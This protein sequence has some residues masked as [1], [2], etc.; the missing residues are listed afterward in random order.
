MPLNYLKNSNWEPFAKKRIQEIIHYYGNT[1]SV[2]LHDQPYAVFDFD[3]TSCFFDIE[4][5]LMLYMIE[6][7]AFR[8]NAETFYHILSCD[9]YETQTILDPN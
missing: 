7:F 8:L 9:S 4:D 3:N 5:H 1:K 2:P 6:Q